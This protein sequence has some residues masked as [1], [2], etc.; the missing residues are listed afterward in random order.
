MNESV[1]YT[2]DQLHAAIS[3]GRAVS[4]R[5]FEYNVQKERVFRRAGADYRV[6]PYGLIWD[7]E[8]YYLAGFDHEK[9]EMR[10][11]RVDKMSGLTVTDLPRE[12]DESC[13]E[14][15]IATYG[16]RHF[17][18]FRGREAQVLRLLDIPPHPLVS[19]VSYTHLA[20]ERSGRAASPGE[21]PWVPPPGDSPSQ[22]P[23]G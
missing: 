6:S 19:P 8:N 23:P 15:D 9:R 2:I 11:Y 7:S 10:H 17:G 5:Y 12:G 13:R 21:G 20:W 16:Q 1:Y 3:A 18:M 4:F 14:F 22:S